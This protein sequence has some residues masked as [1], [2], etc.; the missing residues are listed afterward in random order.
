MTLTEKILL[1]YYLC[2]Q[3]LY[4]QLRKQQMWIMDPGESGDVDN[5]S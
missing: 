3:N 1:F 2:K 4:Q 5:G